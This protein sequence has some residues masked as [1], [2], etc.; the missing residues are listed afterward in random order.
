MESEREGERDEQAWVCR[1]RSERG[2]ARKSERLA[3]RSGVGEDGKY[4]TRLHVSLH[5]HGNTALQKSGK[6]GREGQGEG[7][8]DSFLKQRVI[9]LAQISS[10]NVS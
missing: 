2:K 1:W 5:A 3:Q 8:L 7:Q 9:Q 6:K 10:K 4:A